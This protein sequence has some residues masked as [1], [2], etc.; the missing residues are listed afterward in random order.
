MDELVSDVM[1]TRRWVGWPFGVT[2]PVSVEG[3][4]VEGGWGGVGGAGCGH[5]ALTTKGRVFGISQIFLF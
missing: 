5:E 4:G 3:V 2:F 1:T